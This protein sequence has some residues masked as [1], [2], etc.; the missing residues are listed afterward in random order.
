M[1]PPQTLLVSLD[2][3]AQMIDHSLLHPTM[4]D[5]DVRQGLE[6]SRKYGVATGTT[7]ANIF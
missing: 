7:H 1:S 6:I 2:D 4:T 3:L 5:E